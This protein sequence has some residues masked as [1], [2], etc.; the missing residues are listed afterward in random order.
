MGYQLSYETRKPYKARTRLKTSGGA[1][2]SIPMG[3]GDVAAVFRQLRPQHKI[4]IGYGSHW[5]AGVTLYRD[6]AQ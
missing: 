4:L 2:G 3:C 1:V 6:L 5:A